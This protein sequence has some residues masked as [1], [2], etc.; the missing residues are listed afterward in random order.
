MT[1]LSARVHGGQVIVALSGQLDTTGV[2]DTAAAL[3]AA[4]PPGQPVI[5]D[6]ADLDYMDGNA[7][8]ALTAAHRRARGGDLLLVAPHG[9]VRRM[10]ILTSLDGVIG[11]YPSVA[12]ASAAVS[13]DAAAPENLAPLANQVVGI[14]LG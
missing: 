6:L 14:A 2:A 5:V 7:L 1:T 3:A 13:T 12:A 8:A 11:V 10:L 9:L 4:A